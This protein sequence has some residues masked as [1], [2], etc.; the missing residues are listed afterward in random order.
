MNNNLIKILNN[1][2]IKL[3]TNTSSEHEAEQQAIWLLEHITQKK[4]LKLLTQDLILNKKQEDSLNKYIKEIITKHKPIQYIIGNINFLNLIIQVKEPILIPRPETEEWV[5]FT[6]K[7]L[8]ENLEKYY[9]NQTIKILDLCTGSGCI[10]LALAKNIPNSQVTGIDINPEAIKLANKNKKLNN[11]NNIKFIVSNFY[12]NLENQK[13]DFIF[14][15][16]PYICESEW[17]NLDKNVKN[18]EDKKALVADSNDCL[19]AYKN[20]INNAKNHL[21]INNIFTKNKLSQVFLEIGTEQEKI[22]KLLL[23]EKGLKNIAFRKDL[24]KTT[25]LALASI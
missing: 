11:I 17:Q 21:N 23:E 4:Y 5:D 14:A 3:K 12:E 25:R 24:N 9:K 18:W 20:I 15:N 8:N 19:F 16:P 22:I 2:K 1:I 10:A 13:F 6:I 7:Y